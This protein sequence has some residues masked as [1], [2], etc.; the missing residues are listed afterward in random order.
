MTGRALGARFVLQL[1]PA[2]VA[3]Y[4]PV[5]GIVSNLGTGSGTLPGCWYVEVNAGRLLLTVA[6]GALRTH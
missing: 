3:G 1:V 2:P 6:A 4:W 5:F